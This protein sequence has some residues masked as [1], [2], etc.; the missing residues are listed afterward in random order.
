MTYRCLRN[1]PA[2]KI[3]VELSIDSLTLG[4][5]FTVQNPVNVEKNNEDTHGCTPDPP[6]LL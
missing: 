3:T 5:E 2:Q 6:H 1:G 4:D